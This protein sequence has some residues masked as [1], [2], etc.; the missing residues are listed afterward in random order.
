MKSRLLIP[1][2]LLGLLLFSTGCQTVDTRIKENPAAFASVDKETQEKIKQGIIGIGYTEEM[3]Y[4]ALGQPDQKRES[5][6]ASARTLIWVYNSYTTHYDGMYGMGYGYYSRY[7]S[8]YPYSYYHRPYAYYYPAFGP[9]YTE[10]E[11][12]IRVTFNNGKVTAIDQVHD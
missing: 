9:S 1:L 8:Y 6:T 11:E 10:K 7:P 12:R 3:V 5:V 4:L 2:A